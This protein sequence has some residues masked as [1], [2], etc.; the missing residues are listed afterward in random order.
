MENLIRLNTKKL[1][2]KNKENLISKPIF[3]K[4]NLDKE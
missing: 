3:E 1:T 4:A 2:I